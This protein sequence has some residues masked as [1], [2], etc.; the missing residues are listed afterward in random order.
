[1]NVRVA[2]RVIAIVGKVKDLGWFGN[3]KALDTEFSN[4]VNLALG[5]SQDLRG[6]IM[7]RIPRSVIKQQTLKII[8]AQGQEQPKLKLLR[9]VEL[10]Q[11]K[12]IGPKSTVFDWDRL[13]G[14]QKVIDVFSESKIHSD[15]DRGVLDEA[16]RVLLKFIPENSIKLTDLE[17][18]LK[19]VDKNSPYDI[20]GLSLDTSKSSGYPY[21]ARKYKPSDD[22]SP[23]DRKQSELAWQQLLKDYHLLWPIAYSGKMIRRLKCRTHLRKTSVGSDPEKQTKKGRLVIAVEKVEAVIGKRYVGPEQQALKKVTFIRKP[24]TKPDQYNVNTVDGI[25][26]FNAWHDL[27][28]IDITQQKIL[29]LAHEQNLIVVSG[30]VS[31]F[32]ASLPAELIWRVGEMDAYWCDAGKVPLVM[33]KV[34]TDGLSLV[35]PFQIHQNKHGSMPSG[36]VHTNKSDSLA[37]SLVLLYGHVKGIYDLY[38]YEVNGDDFTAVGHNVTPDTISA[39]FNLFNL[40]VHPDKQFYEPDMLA[41]L[42]RMHIYGQIGGIASMERILNSITSYERRRVKSSDW[43]PYIEVVRVLAQ[44]ENGAFSPWFEDIVY[45][46]ARRDKFRLGADLP[47]TEVMR[48][49]GTTGIDVMTKD[50][51]GAWQSQGDPEGFAN[52]AVNGVL[53]GESLP[54]IG[55]KQRFER[56]YGKRVDQF[57]EELDKLTFLL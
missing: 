3:Q 18:V 30:D 40:E 27:P 44:L 53:R 20:G 12:K 46:V 7:G 54:P 35:T 42:Q 43:N 56:V 25:H 36:S 39:V 31:G 37:L 22:Q 26:P 47:A 17:D 55:S 28:F 29:H 52:W 10:D 21:M 38:A 32:D 49:A 45:Y 24:D 1:M 14:E 2:K 57:R 23:V 19:D 51:I 15:V 5:D 11:S 6:L 41:Y 13:K 9:Q 8:K 4:L 50:V 34:M 16:Q 33:S 48:R